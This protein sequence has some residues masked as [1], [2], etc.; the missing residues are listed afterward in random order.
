MSVQG[1][2]GVSVVADTRLKAMAFC[3]FTPALDDTRDSGVA[4]LEVRVALCHTE[5]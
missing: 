3:C 2:M 4:L 1:E 5:G